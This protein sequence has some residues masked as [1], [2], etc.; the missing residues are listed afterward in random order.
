MNT[1]QRIAKNTGVL[2]VS[3]VMS[4]I[5]NFL[6]VMYTARYL[7]A[8]EFGIFSFALAFA[9]IFAVF[10]DLGLSILTVR[11]VARDKILVRFSLNQ[12]L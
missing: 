3:Q 7:G 10:L 11:E 5:M 2:F 1:I 6:F 8:E 9:A 12:K 4:Y